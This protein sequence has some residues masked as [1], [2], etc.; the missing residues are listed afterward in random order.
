MDWKNGKLAS[1]VVKSLNS[2]LCI[3]KTNVPIK[4]TGSVSTT[5]KTESSFVNKFKTEKGKTY[6]IQAVY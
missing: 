6:K 1:S 4:V 5:E 2:E 3:I